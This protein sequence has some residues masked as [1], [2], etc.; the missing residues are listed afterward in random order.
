MPEISVVKDKSLK[1]FLNADYTKRSKAVRR[2]FSYELA[3][4]LLK[5]IKKRIPT[6]EE[7]LDAYRDS[8]EIYDVIDSPKNETVFVIASKVP[9]KWSMAD[10]D[11]TV[12]YFETHLNNAIGGILQEFS[13]FSVDQI[14]S[15]A[16]YGSAAVI[17]R[18]RADEIID[19]R[20]ANMR[21]RG[22]LNRRLGVAKAVFKTGPPVIDGQLY[23]DINFAVMRMELGY[24]DIRKPHW[25]PVLRNMLKHARRVMQIPKMQK[26]L[27]KCL[28]P[29]Y[30]QYSRELKIKRNKMRVSALWGLQKMQRKLSP[31]QR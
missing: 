27:L 6:G 5:E 22:D 21:N 30:N 19:V 14:P 16:T 31:T 4:S 9:A 23:F 29:A 24:G 11:K 28:N 18:V 26:R 10:V 1:K 13:P 2:A 17:R 25:K 7:W 15:L 12:V 8:F 3:S 20:S